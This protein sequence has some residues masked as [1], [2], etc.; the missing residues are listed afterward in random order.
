MVEEASEHPTEEEGHADMTKPI[1]C[2]MTITFNVA[3]DEITP[4]AQATL[5]MLAAF[6]AV[7][8]AMRQLGLTKDQA[9]KC[10]SEELA[11][12]WDQVERNGDRV[13]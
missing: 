8:L 11:H 13:S 2:K 3:K 9:I 10:A 1:D 5:T 7:A 6:R 4:D 12:A